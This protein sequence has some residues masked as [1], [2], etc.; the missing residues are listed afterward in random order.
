MIKVKNA[1]TDTVKNPIQIILV[2]YTKQIA[3]KVFACLEETFLPNAT[4]M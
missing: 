2:L 3:T 4:E 1:S